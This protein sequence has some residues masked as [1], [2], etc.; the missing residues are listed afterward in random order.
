[1]VTAL[2]FGCG[3]ELWFS[4]AMASRTCAKPSDGGPELGRHGGSGPRRR[5]G[6]GA[7]A[8]GVPSKGRRKQAKGTRMRAS[9]GRAGTRRLPIG[10]RERKRKEETA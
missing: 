4:V 10:S 7:V 5:R 3:E 8:M 6:L 1:M 2:R 9:G